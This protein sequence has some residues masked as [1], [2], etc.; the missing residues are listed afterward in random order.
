MRFNELP[1]SSH[2]KQQY[3]LDIQEE[4]DESSRQIDDSKKNVA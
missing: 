1:F 2:E 3:L 4:A